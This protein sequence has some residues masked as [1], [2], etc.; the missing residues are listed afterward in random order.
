[1]HLCHTHNIG[2]CTLCGNNATQGIRLLKKDKAECV[3]LLVL[4]T[5]FDTLVIESPKDGGDNLSEITL[6]ADTKYMT[7]VLNPSLVVC[8]WQE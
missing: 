3:E 1:M 7:T 4:A 6:D 2:N 5:L 8:S